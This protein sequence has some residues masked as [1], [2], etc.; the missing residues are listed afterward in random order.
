MRYQI[1]KQDSLHVF[2]HTQM[3]E[4][5]KGLANQLQEIFILQC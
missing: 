1:L 2:D 3:R 5:G 4:S